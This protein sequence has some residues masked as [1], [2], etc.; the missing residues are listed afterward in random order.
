MDKL[1]R[2]NTLQLEAQKYG[3]D[4]DSFGLEKARF[5]SKVNDCARVVIA[6]IKPSR[7][8][9]NNRRNH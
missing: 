8:D 4:T 9:Y 6:P 1:R 2:A 3:F 7:T 5:L